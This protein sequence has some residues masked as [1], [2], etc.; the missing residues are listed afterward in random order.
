MMLEI[1]GCII[2]QHDPWLML[3]A[4]GVCV[5][6]LIA[7]FLLHDRA[8]E[9]VEVRRRNWGGAGRDHGRRQHLVHAFPVDACLSGPLPLGFDL[10]LTLTSIAAPA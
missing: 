9:C 10:P 1:M 3:P 2:G 8:E 7:L 4:L 5:L 6:G